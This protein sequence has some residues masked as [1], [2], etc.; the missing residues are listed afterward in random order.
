MEVNGYASGHW[1]GTDFIDGFTVAADDLDVIRP[2]S[3]LSETLCEVRM[4]G[5]TGSKIGH[6]LVEMVFVGAYPRYG[7]TGW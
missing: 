7:Y 2:V 5:P 3:F 1:R 6:G 4:D